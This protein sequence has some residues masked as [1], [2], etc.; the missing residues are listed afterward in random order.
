MSAADYVGHYYKVEGESVDER[1]LSTLRPY[2]SVPLITFQTL[3]EAW[4]DEY[5]KVVAPAKEVAG[6][7]DQPQMVPLLADLVLKPAVEHALFSGSIDE[8]EFIM[9]ISDKRSKIKEILRSRQDPIPDSGIP[10]LSKLLELETYDQHEK[11]LDISQFP[12]SD[13]QILDIVAQHAD[14]GV[15]NISHNKQV[16]IDVVEKLLVAL[17]KLRRLLVLN[18]SITEEDAIALL[19]QRPELFRNLE[20]FIHPAFLT[21]KARFKGAYIHI[22]NHR[23]GLYAVS[24]PFF[25]TGQI[26]QGLTDY[27]NPLALDSLSRLSDMTQYENSVMAAY[28]SQVR[29]PGQS[30]EE[31]VASFVPATLPPAQSLARKGRQ[32]LFVLLPVVGGTAGHRYY[33]LIYAFARVSGEVWDEYLKMMEQIDGETENSGPTAPMSSQ[34]KAERVSELHK[35]LGPRL[36]E[37]FDMQ[38]FFKEL[39][40]EGREPPS[41]EALSQLFDIF[42][43]LD[44]RKDYGP[45]LI[46]VDQL[47]MLFTKPPQSWMSPLIWE[48]MQLDLEE[49]IRNPAVRLADATTSA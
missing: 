24:V 36:F 12:L 49:W 28:A 16:T 37:I 17:P 43:N 29:R 13:H 26:I 20:G 11:T 15:L 4:P 2:E 6:D 33:N 18:T 39:E 8:L 41:P 5:V 22:S 48:H 27:L 21:D 10:L 35:G 40:L 1:I 31:R 32:W 34:E 47:V 23:N 9:A 30:W 3:A 14:L 19:E 38:Q 44:T 45:Q 42:S 46:D 7:G 25:T